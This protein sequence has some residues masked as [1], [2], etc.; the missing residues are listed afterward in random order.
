M[1]CWARSSIW[2]EVDASRIERWL[3]GH[4]REL[5]QAGIDPRMLREEARFRAAALQAAAHRTIGSRMDGLPAGAG[6]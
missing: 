2:M 4:C 6:G 5:A 1:R 3:A